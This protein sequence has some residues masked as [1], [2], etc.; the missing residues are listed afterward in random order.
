MSPPE[1]NPFQAP[2]KTNVAGNAPATDKERLDF[3]GLAKKWERYR[4]IY[5]GI[6]VFETIALSLVANGI[7]PPVELVVAAV[8]GA[9]TVNFFFLLGPVLDGYCQWIF[10]SR[11]PVFGLIILVVGTLF[12]MLLAGGTVVAIAASIPVLF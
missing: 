5:N 2:I 8:L 6:L 3:I 9:L 11:S 4:L 12:S 1:S 10:G 7:V